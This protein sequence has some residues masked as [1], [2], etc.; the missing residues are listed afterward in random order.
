M[1][2]YHRPS[3]S[4]QSV[5]YIIGSRFGS[6]NNASTNTIIVPHKFILQSNCQLIM[7]INHGIKRNDTTN[8]IDF[9]IISIIT[10]HL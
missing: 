1:T 3:H 9:V 6:K 10:T 7:I 5:I 2:P 8:H 4:R